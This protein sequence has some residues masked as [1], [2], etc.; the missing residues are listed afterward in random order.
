MSRNTR[1]L[2]VILVAVGILL[3]GAGVIGGTL[4]L[5]SLRKPDVPATTVVDNFLT[6]IFTHHDEAAAL[7]MV[8][9]AGQRDGSGVRKRLHNYVSP[10]GGTIAQLHWN[11]L[12]QAV[13]SEKAIVIC[14]ATVLL[15]YTSGQVVDISRGWFFTLR[16]VHRKWLI[17]EWD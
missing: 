11:D 17:D 5:R 4:V 16:P 3:V 10:D 9:A 6:A 7:A 2:I 1:L 13:T 15:R 12:R 8:T 14:T